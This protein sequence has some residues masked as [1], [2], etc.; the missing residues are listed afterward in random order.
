[1][2]TF[3]KESEG[4]FLR[5]SELENACA[6][7]FYGK[8]GK[9]ALDILV[10]V[11]GLI[12]LSPVFTFV[13]CII[14]LTSRGPVFY[15]QIRIGRSGCPFNIVKFRSMK[16]QPSM[17]DLKITIAGDPRVTPIGRFLRHYKIDELP[18]LW[19]VMLGNMSLVGPRPEVP[20]YTE[21]YTTEQR[22]V[23]SARPGITDPASLAYRQEEDILG[24]Q[25]DPE[26]YY[27]TQILPDKLAQNIAY[28][29]E[30]SFRNDVLIIIR[31]ISA[32]FQYSE[33]SSRSVHLE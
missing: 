31:T 5:D 20:A 18:Q 9:R 13:A 11:T 14:K 12:L 15:R 28:L 16:T 33:K 22:A 10:A 30:I 26:H 2:E 29:K 17:G 4:R 7:S 6:Q 24:S 1:M 21:G 27:R 19:N 23:L 25:N 8:Y 32:C 3:Y